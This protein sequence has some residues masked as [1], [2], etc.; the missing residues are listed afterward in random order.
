MSGLL[1]DVKVL[2]EFSQDNKGCCVENLSKETLIYSVQGP[3]SL[4]ALNGFIND[5]SLSNPLYF[6][7]AK[8]RFNGIPSL[9]GRLGY[10]GE[11]GFEIILPA[12]NHLQI[13]NSLSNKAHLCGFSAVDRLRIKAGFIL[14]A[15]EF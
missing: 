12:E 4:K 7:F 2:I 10:T 3:Y 6:G 14:F 5:K 1:E 9:I 11:Q 8:F 13:L 15:N